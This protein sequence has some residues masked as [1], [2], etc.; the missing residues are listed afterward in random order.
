MGYNTSVHEPTGHTPFKL[1]F[2][3][4]ANLASTISA[5][6][7]ITK[8]QLFK[9]WKVRHDTDIQKAIE[10]T[11]QNKKRYQ[12]E[13]NRKIIKTQTVFNI[14]DKVWI[15]TNHKRNKLDHEW[16]RPV[17]IIQTSPPIYTIRYD[18]NHTQKIHDNRLK[19]YFSG[20][21]LLCSSSS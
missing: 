14:G 11:N 6:P 7:S 9:L 12:R 4:K 20:Q 13:Q 17:E 21:L 2:G 8:E 16:L 18:D 3:Y 15:H 10:I 19:P 1:N 5:T